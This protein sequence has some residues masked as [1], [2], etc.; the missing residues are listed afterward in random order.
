VSNQ[1]INVD[2]AVRDEDTFV[3]GDDDDDD[4]SGDE[5]TESP[6]SQVSSSLP[7][8]Y[9]SL[10][11]SL[12][13]GMPAHTAT[14]ESQTHVED[15][16]GPS[17]ETATSSRYYIKPNDSLKGIALRFGVNGHELC[18][19]N[20]LPPSTLSTTP[21]I[22]HTRAFLTLPPSAR[23]QAKPPVLDTEREIRLSRE[24]AEKRLQMLTKEVDWRVAKAY[25]ALADGA[26]SDAD[27][28]RKESSH[29]AEMNVLGDER[30]EFTLEERAVD[31]YLDDKEWERRER[32]EGRTTTIR[33]FPYSA[34]KG[35]RE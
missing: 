23:S 28:K 29:E 24:R 9:S 35:W 12:K 3:L 13:P 20:N 7:P 33:P 6:D 8:P 22:L 14:Q 1:I 25:V 5:H 34:A 16:A 21:H 18:R 17:T 19:L 26:E 32:S 27:L 2:G 4:E 11:Q 15:E 30:T 31:Q 10:L